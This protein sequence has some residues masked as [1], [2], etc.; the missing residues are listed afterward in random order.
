[1]ESA[2]TDS[3][4][5][6]IMFYQS[7]LQS[8]PIKT[9]S[10]G[11]G[12]P[13]CLSANS[14]TK[15]LTAIYTQLNCDSIEEVSLEMNPDLITESYLCSLIDLKFNRI[16]LGVQSSINSELA[17]LER[18]HTFNDVRRVVTLFDKYG[19][20]NYNFDLIY[21]LPNSNIHTIDTILHDY[22]SLAPKHL[23]TYS[24][25]ISKGTDFAKRK[26]K[27]VNEEIECLQYEYIQSLLEDHGYNQYELSCFCLTDEYKSIHNSQ[28]WKYDPYIGLGPS[29]WSYF[30]RIL[31]QQT[32]DIHSYLKNSQSRVRLQLEN[33]SY[34]IIEEKKDF[35]IANFRFVS[36]LNMSRYTQR[37]ES[38]FLVEYNDQLSK[39]ID[40]KLAILYQ[41]HVQL[42]KKGRL[43]YD[44]VIDY[45][46]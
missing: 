24:L 26:I 19:F 18:S 39:L 13:N 10:F 14:L 28:Y 38:E 21:G 27:P 8:T 41:D 20:E 33:S 30:N 5:D 37:F 12:T 32:S 9:I 1:M 45:F 7:L 43:L 44:S 22:L 4:V 11:G 25:T 36:G 3:I 35:I 23:S 16:S 17:F 34:S 29:S 40:L 42:T 31:Y 6:E 2:F 15:I 46:I